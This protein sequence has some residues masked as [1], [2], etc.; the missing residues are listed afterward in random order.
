MKTLF[1]ELVDDEDLSDETMLVLFN[2][3]KNLLELEAKP[4]FLVAK[5]TS[6]SGA[7]GDTYLITKALP[8]DFRFMKK[9]YYDTLELKPK[10]FIDSI[11]YKDSANYYFIDHA[12]RVFSQSGRVGKA[13]TYTLFYQKKTP[14]IT[15]LTSAVA[16]IVLWPSEFH[17]LIPFE[18]AMI[19]QQT[20]DGDDLAFRLSAGQEKQYNTL[21][22][23]FM[24]YSADLAL[25][26][27]DD[28]MGYDE[29]QVPFDIG[30]M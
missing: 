7:V 6:L 20:M 28:T 1:I 27:D 19:Y 22:E 30:R 16:T 18:A 14:D 15:D 17:A 10:S 21:R 12:N 23:S 5:D 8:T 13:S 4:P 3:A 26:D 9:L 11:M 2:K 24:S 29:E 25:G